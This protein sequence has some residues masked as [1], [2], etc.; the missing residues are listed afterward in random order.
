MEEI[1]TAYMFLYTSNSSKAVL[2]QTLALHRVTPFS[3]DHSGIATLHPLRVAPTNRT[4][5]LLARD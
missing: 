5:V 1:Q 3:S 2:F 4:A